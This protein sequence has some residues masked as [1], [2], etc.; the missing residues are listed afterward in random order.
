MSYIHIMYI[1]SM[2]AMSYMNICVHNYIHNLFL[3]CINTYTCVYIYVILIYISFIFTG[4]RLYI[5]ND[6]YIYMRM[7]TY[8]IT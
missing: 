8:S 1:L 4:I 7:H 2:L 6:I 3:C 5:Y